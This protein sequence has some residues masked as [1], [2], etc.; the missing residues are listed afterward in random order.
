M[1]AGRVDNGPSQSRGHTQYKQH[2]QQLL[3]F[4]LNTRQCAKTF[5]LVWSYS[6]MYAILC[7]C[8]RWVWAWGSAMAVAMAMMKVMVMGVGVGVGAAYP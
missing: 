2:P 6:S 5:G 7:L 8:R 4:A 1:Q 3:L